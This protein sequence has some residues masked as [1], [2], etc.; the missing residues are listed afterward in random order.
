MIKDLHHSIDPTDIIQELIQKG[1][2]AKNA[3]NKQKWRTAE[4][5]QDR[6]AKGLQG[7]SAT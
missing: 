5:R 2:K 3:T 4:Q 1:L 6:R 7:S